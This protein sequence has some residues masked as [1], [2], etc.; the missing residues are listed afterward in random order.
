MPEEEGVA[1]DKRPAA[2]AD[3]GK[4]RAEGRAG[5]ERRTGKARIIGIGREVSGRRKDG[6]VFPMDLSVSEVKL[7]DRRLF[8][9]FIRD[10]TERKRLEKN[11]RPA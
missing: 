3:A 8:T 11:A 1:A 2:N 6:S 7:A 4:A 5:R 10:I 9:G